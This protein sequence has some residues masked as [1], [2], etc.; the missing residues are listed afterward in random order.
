[1]KALTERARAVKAL[2]EQHVG[3]ARDAAAGRRVRVRVRVPGVFA[4]PPPPERKG[5][6]RSKARRERDV[7]DD[8]GLYR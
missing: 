8:R 4:S 7:Y 1:V 3:H 5:R 6:S 2:T